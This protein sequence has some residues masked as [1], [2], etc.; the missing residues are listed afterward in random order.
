MHTL[1]KLVRLDQE[2]DS[3]TPSALYLP[4][5][6]HYQFFRQI[7]SRPVSIFGVKTQTHTHTQWRVKD[8]ESKVGWRGGQGDKDRTM[9]LA[10]QLTLHSD[11]VAITSKA[12]KRFLNKS[13]RAKKSPTGLS[14]FSPICFAPIEHSPRYWESV[15][16]WLVECK[17]H[18]HTGPISKCLDRD[19]ISVVFKLYYSTKIQ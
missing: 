9:L 15:D 8:W 3:L 10:N 4:S 12:A 1:K 17:R 18:K 6:F 19:T 13:K 2:Q 11:G 16:S 7:H 14:G 5:T